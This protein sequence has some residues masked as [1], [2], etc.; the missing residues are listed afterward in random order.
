MTKLVVGIGE[1]MVSKNPEDEIKTYALGSCVALVFLDPKTRCVGM[2]HFALPDSA[3]NKAKAKDLPAYFVDTGIPHLIKQMQG[4]GSTPHPKYLTKLVGG[5]NVIKDQNQFLI[6]ERNVNA[7]KKALWQLNL[8]LVA[9]DVGKNFS[10]TVSV[11]L[12]TGKLT[13][14]SASGEHWSI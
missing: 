5:A 10:R 1:S 4:I 7:V 12:K 11:L 13:I 6:G 2:A 14:S 9:S 8:P 3:T